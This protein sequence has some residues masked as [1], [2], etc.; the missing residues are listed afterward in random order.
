M[1]A[2]GIAVGDGREPPLSRCLRPK[3]SRPEK[4]FG[5]VERF[6]LFAR[7]FSSRLRQYRPE[8]VAI[9]AAF[10][11]EKFDEDGKRKGNPDTARIL[12][13]LAAIAQAECGRIGLSPVQV[14][15]VNIGTWRK[16]V[17]GKGQF[18]D[19]IDPFT[20]KKIKGRTLAKNASLSFCRSIGWDTAND[21]NRADACGL[22]AYAHTCLPDGNQR[23]VLKMMSR[24]RAAI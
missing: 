13:G 22:W 1:S 8:L 10:I 23:D 21:D 20:K 5:D 4:G 19:Q 6:T 24:A 11:G 2:T 15:L 3:I 18:R 12:F 7:W 14:H 9:E 16:N 17:L